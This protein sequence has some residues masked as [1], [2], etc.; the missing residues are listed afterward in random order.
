MSTIAMSHK[1]LL[2]C[3]LTSI[4]Q[5][6]PT[7]VYKQTR[8]I[9]YKAHTR[10]LALYFSPQHYILSFQQGLPQKPN[11]PPISPTKPMC[12]HCQTI[13][14]RTQSDCAIC[15]GKCAQACAHPDCNKYPA[16]KHDPVSD[17]P[18]SVRKF[19]LNRLRD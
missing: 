4:R 12:M 8:E 14:S 2:R 11:M 15:G 6:W 19:M 3:N 9:M 10:S 1:D 7:P 18:R 13:V 16:V 17:P 5:R